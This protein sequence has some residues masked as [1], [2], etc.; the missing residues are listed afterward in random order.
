MDIKK[1]K[2]PCQ[3]CELRGFLFRA[4]SNCHTDK[5]CKWVRYSMQK[6]IYDDAKTDE[7]HANVDIELI[8]HYRAARIAKKVN[9]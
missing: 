2:P 5:C 8:S 9:R 6:K 1:P 7:Y 4:D 3:H